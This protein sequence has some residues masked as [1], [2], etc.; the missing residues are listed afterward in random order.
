MRRTLRPLPGSAKYDDF[1]GERER[2]RLEAAL[3][4]DKVDRVSS[5]SPSTG[6]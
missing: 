5:P 2:K 1:M 6:Q 3:R 4:K